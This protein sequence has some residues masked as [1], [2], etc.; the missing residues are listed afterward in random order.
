M[1]T[2]TYTDTLIF[3]EQRNNEIVGTTTRDVSEMTTTDLID[4]FVQIMRL[5]GY[6]DV[7]IW[8]ALKEKSQDMEEYFDSIHSSKDE[9]SEEEIENDEHPYVV[10]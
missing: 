1:H 8:R 6:H 3:T 10:F 9:W 5:K 4:T 7:S 2:D